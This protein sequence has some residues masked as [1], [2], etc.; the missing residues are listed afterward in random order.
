M[1]QLA[2]PLSAGG[3]SYAAEDFIVSESNQHAHHQV[4]HADPAQSYG[5]WLHG[6]AAS[7]KTHLAHMFAAHT[8]AKLLRAGKLPLQGFPALVVVDDITAQTNP[9]ALFHLLN[10]VKQAGGLALLVS[11]HLPRDLGWE[12]KDTLS[13]LNALPKAALLPPD[14]LLLEA[15]WFKLLADRQLSV[16]PEVITWLTRR[17]ARDAC[18]ISEDVAKLDAAALQEKRK[19]TIPFVKE[20]LG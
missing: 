6:P 9:E 3:T 1:N 11:R 20:I 14:D 7:G 12:L 19:L 2:M 4:L 13:R 18:S 16:S 8:G 17:G 5:L 15:L 10:H